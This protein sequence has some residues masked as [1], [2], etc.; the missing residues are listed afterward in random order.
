[1]NIKTI[2]KES[3]ITISDAG[4]IIILLNVNEWSRPGKPYT[5]EEVIS[6]KDFLIA[7]D[8]SNEIVGF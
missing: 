5:T 6:E 3:G 8:E 1:M 4:K 7:Y 2:Y